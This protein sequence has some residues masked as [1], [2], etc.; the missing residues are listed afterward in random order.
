MCFVQSRMTIVSSIARH[1]LLITAVTLFV[2][3]C[4]DNPKSTV[5]PS[6]FQEIVLR[7]VQGLW[8]GN[9]L[10]LYADGRLIVQIAKPPSVLRYESLATAQEMKLVQELLDNHRFFE[11]KSSTRS[12][13]PDEGHPKID[14]KTTAGQSHAVMRWSNDKDADFDAIYQ[15]LLLIARRASAAQPAYEGQYDWNWSPDAST[16]RK[17]IAP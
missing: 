4:S 14:V 5:S 8:G 16:T 12:A 11:L 7:D 1:L 3:T 9:D 13:M 17:S 2:A 6:P 15:Q 10:W